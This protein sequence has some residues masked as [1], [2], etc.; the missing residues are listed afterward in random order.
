MA[1]GE[2]LAGDPVYDL[3]EQLNG[4][5]EL[6]TP[7]RPLGRVQGPRDEGRHPEWG[8][9]NTYLIRNKVVEATSNP[10]TNLWTCSFIENDNLNKCSIAIMT[11][12]V[13]SVNHNVT[14]EQGEKV[15]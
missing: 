7:L 13:Y 1:V 12:V 4:D 9:V 2:L 8:K 14:F 15:L 10:T 3:I 6:L 5:V 11:S